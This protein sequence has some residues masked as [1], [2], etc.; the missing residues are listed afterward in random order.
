LHYVRE[1][2]NSFNEIAFL[3]GFTEPA[4]LAHALKRW[5]GNTASEFCQ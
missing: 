2:R 5:H 4:N 1:T 3:P